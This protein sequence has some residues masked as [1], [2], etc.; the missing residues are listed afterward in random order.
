[1][2]GSLISAVLLTSLLLG[3]IIFT[4]WRQSLRDDLAARMHDLAAT[5]ALMVDPALH[6]GLQTPADMES[7]AYQTLRT[8]LQKVRNASPDIHFLYTYRWI[9]GEAKPRFVVDSGT[10]GV[11]FSPLG[12][13]CD[14][15]T[16]ILRASFS[17]PWSVKVE[18]AFYTDQWG[19]WL[20]AFAPMVAADGSLEGVLGL[21][22]DAL[23]L[24]H[25][26]QGIVR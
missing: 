7:P 17:P 14:T 13:E 2:A 15:L 25:I 21:D 1:M 6:Q 22:M 4:I 19:T 11:D 24:I 18:T 26:S 8:Q 23:S 3:G 16:P 12:Q 10:E 5:T 20:S 9:E